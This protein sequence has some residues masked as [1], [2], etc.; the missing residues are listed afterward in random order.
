M[1]AYEFLPDDKDKITSRLKE[2]VDVEEINL[3]FTTGGTG[4]F[5]GGRVLVSA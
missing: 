4:L 2:L 5:D 1:K 3:I